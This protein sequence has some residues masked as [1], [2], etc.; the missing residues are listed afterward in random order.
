MT[1]ICSFVSKL[2]GLIMQQVERGHM[3][4]QG[5]SAVVSNDIRCWFSALGRSKITNA[6]R[7]YFTT[8]VHLYAANWFNSTDLIS[9]SEQSKLHLSQFK[10]NCM[11]LHDQSKF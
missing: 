9:L 4:K 6:Q 11:D 3:E 8:F 10:C 2:A 5:N 1:A 7:L